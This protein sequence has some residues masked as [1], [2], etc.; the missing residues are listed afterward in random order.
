MKHTL[1]IGLVALATFTA[2]AFAGG[3]ER[4]H[5]PASTRWLAHVDLERFVGTELF[6]GANERGLGSEIKLDEMREELGIDPMKDVLSVTVFGASED[7]EDSI[8]LIVLTEAGAEQVL[9]KLED[10]E[11]HVYVETDGVRLHAWTEGDVIEAYAYEKRVKAGRLLI[12]SDDRD[13]LHQAIRVVEDEDPSLADAENALLSARPSPGSF[14]YVEASGVVPGLDD[15]EP[16]ATVNEL[17]EGLVCDVSET[18][19]E[20]SIELEIATDSSADAKSV[21]EIA[22]GGLALLQLIARQSA[23]G[24]V[25]ADLIGALGLGHDGGRMQASFRYDSRALLAALDE[26]EEL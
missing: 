9:R 25:C 3:V 23:P 1:V 18:D 5:L 17:V 13:R 12:L 21:F 4:D 20:L 7:P 14:F 26:L 15:L 11:R 2:P 19:G 24:T 22:Q 16:A 6:A 10:E 8:A